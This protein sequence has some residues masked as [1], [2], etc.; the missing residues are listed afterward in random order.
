MGHDRLLVKDAWRRFSDFPCLLS[1]VI[2]GYHTNTGAASPSE[3]GVSIYR[4]TRCYPEDGGSIFIPRIGIYLQDG[5]VSP[6]RRSQTAEYVGSNCKLT[7]CV[8]RSN[9]EWFETLSTYA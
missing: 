4:I 8:T 1:N 7:R 2:G 6:P 5:T 3:M 9:T